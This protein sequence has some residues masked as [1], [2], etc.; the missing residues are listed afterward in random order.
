MNRN[1]LISEIA[2]RTNQTKKDVIEFVN[3]YEEAIIDAI[4][5]GDSVLLHGFMR[6][7]RKKKKQYLGH[8][9]GTKDVKVVPERD[10]VKI[11]PGT[12]LSECI[13]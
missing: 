2:N 4:K 6:I 1:E 11:R 8:G 10:F 7:E 9:F 5:G 13:K 12:S 3:A